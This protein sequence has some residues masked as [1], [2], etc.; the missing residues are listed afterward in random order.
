MMRINLVM[1]I[2]C[3]INGLLVTTNALTIAMSTTSSFTTDTKD[4]L[5]SSIE[6]IATVVS[7]PILLIVLIITVVALIWSYKRRSA[8]HKVNV[9]DTYSTLNRGSRQTRRQQITQQDSAEL[10]NQIHLSPSTGQT[11]FISKPQSENI[12]NPHSY[13]HPTHPDT[14]NSVTNESTASQTNSSIATYAAIDKG[15]KKKA[16]KE[17]DAKQIAAEKYTQY[18]KVS[19]I[20]G[21]HA[22]NSTQISLEY[23]C[24]SDHQDKERVNSDQESNPS[25]SF[26]ELYTAVQKKPKGSSAPVNESVPQ[27][28]EDLYTAVMKKPKENSAN[29]EVVPPIP[30]HTVEELYTAVHK[31]PVGNIMAQEDEEEAPPIP[32]LNVEDI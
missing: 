32:P 5:N 30:P 23:M 4:K 2:M 9:D 21:A 20:R 15:N 18:Q 31:K 10:Y 28:A 19:S 17:D 6:I 13:S 26:E 24:A 1:V 16:K 7:I 22:G 8:K 12:N 29:D 3:N 25:H 27:M 14:E 11:E